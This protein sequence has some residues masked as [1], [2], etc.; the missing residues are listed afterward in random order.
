[1]GRCARRTH[2]ARRF[3]ICCPIRQRL[4]ARVCAPAC[5]RPRVRASL[6]ALALAR[7]VACVCRTSPCSCAGA[8]GSGGKQREEEAGGGAAQG[9]RQAG[10]Q[11]QERAAEWQ[12]QRGWEVFLFGVFAVLAPSLRV[13]TS[14]M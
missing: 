2:S 5:A 9:C 11:K 12:L 3:L 8:R 13:L 4:R 10:H 1:M 7:D 6:C 14:Q